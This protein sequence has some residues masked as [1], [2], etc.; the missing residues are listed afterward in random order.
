MT[1]MPSQAVFQAYTRAYELFFRG[2]YRGSQEVAQQAALLDSTY[3]PLKLVLAVVSLN[4][5]DYSRADSLLDAVE[6]SL[7]QLGPGGQL[8]FRWIRSNLAGDRVAAHQSAKEAVQYAASPIWKWTLGFEALRM[9]RP[10]E[11]LEVLSEIDPD[12]PGMVGV[13]GYWEYLTEAL[14]TLDQHKRELK[15]AKKGR[16]RHP[17]SPRVLRAEIRARAALGNVQ[18]LTDLVEESIRKDADPVQAFRVAALELRAHEHPEASLAMGEMALAYLRGRPTELTAT[19]G[20]RYGLLQALYIMERWDEAQPIADELIH[21]DPMNPDYLGYLGT[22]AVRRGER[23]EALRISDELASVD[24]PYL[25]GSNTLW[26]ARIAA[27]LGEEERAVSFLRQ[28]HEQGVRLDVS[29]HRD[30]DLEPLRDSP[31]FE[32]FTRPRG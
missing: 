29:I 12:G 17:D 31:S 26:R 3:A 21:E 22:L 10:R 19:S 6:S 9:N 28:A 7:A 1:S 20:P 16:D 27:L 15:E 2:D 24:R 5:G 8:Q 4:V 14:H 25:R 13:P 30:M 11:A 23:V 32:E 18:E